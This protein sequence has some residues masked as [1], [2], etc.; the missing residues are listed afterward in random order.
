MK[1]EIWSDVMCPFCYIGKRNFETALEQFEHKN[2]LEVV[3]KSYQ[4]DSNIPEE[5]KDSYQ[6]YLV[7]NKGMSQEQ[8]KGMLDNVTLS[9]KQVGLEYNFDKAVMVNSLNAHKFIQ[10][11]KTKGLGDQAEEK[12]FLAFFTEGK[13][14][15]DIDTLVQIGKELELGEAEVK[16]ALND[17][18]FVSLF[19]QDIQEAR[20][21]GVQGVPFFVLDR[22]YGVSGA[23]PPQAFLENLEVA[24]DEWRKLNPETKLEVTQGQSCSPDGTC[25]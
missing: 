18:K 13:N 11:A 23:Q 5:P 6:D 3:W 19:K 10:F 22:K 14:I 12:L 25:E 9:A 4:L 1:I 24:F 16:A 2:E 20:E 17:E 8:V 21:L 15:A 7:K